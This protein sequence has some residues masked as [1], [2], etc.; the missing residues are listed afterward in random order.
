MKKR[1][2]LYTV[3]HRENTIMKFMINIETVERKTFVI[4]GILAINTFLFHNNNINFERS[5]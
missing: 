1:V 5:R 3:F 4:S 2:K